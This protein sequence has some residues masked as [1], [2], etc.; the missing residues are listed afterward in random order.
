M[1]LKEGIA[2][3]AEKHSKRSEY[4]QKMLELIKKRR[5][6]KWE[7]EQSDEEDND[8]ASDGYESDGEE[9]ED[10]FDGME[11]EDGE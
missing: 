11:D 8:E 6:S 5:G 2:L 1:D 4:F 7:D 10:D 3:D 9:G